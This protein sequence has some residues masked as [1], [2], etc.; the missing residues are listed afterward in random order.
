MDEREKIDK[1][2]AL[3]SPD[4]SNLLEKLQ[5]EQKNRF[6][7][8][9]SS[10]IALLILDRLDKLGLSKTELALKMHVSPSYVSKMVK[11]HENFTLETIVKHE[12]VL[13]L[14]ILTNLREPPVQKWIVSARYEQTTLVEAWQTFEY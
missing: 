14:Q 1:F 8:R 11:G 12:R 9:K 10:D 6:W 3:V 2:M 5:W 7:L 13:G 4:K